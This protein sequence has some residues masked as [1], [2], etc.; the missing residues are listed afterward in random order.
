MIYARWYPTDYDDALN[1]DLSQNGTAAP[2]LEKAVFH[3][4]ITD[5]INTDIVL[6]RFNI[7][8]AL[9]GQNGTYKKK[10]STG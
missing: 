1:N 7:K 3:Y 8:L 9:V 5:I 4:D 2:H 10:L 6:L